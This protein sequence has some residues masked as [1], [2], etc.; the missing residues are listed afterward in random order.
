[1]V[2]DRPD[3]EDDRE[4]EDRAPDRE[5]GDRPS[6]GERADRSS[7]RDGDGGPPNGE[8]DR[9][10]DA[11]DRR[12]DEN[13]RTGDRRRREG[14]RRPDDRRPGEEALGAGGPFGIGVGGHIGRLLEFLDD[15]GE[16]SDRSRR[17]PST[18]GDRNRLG[19]TPKGKPSSSDRFSLDFDVSIGSLGGDERSGDR[20]GRSRNRRRRGRVADDAGEHLT[21]TRY[22]GE[23]VVLTADLPGVET[24]DLTV[25]VTEDGRTLVVGADGE[26]LARLPVENWD[27][28]AVSATFN[29]F[30]LE[31]RV[32]DDVVAGD[33]EEVAS[34]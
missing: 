32:D 2:H 11:D 34:R 6:D 1:M 3:D 29:N 14:D 8:D 7:D 17:G 26:E 10:I 33:P 5:S 22:D 15:A 30:V 9:S 21:T 23:D 20:G 24:S 13:D 31:V 27:E 12:A 4:G 25:G 16:N 19:R 18:G 28:S